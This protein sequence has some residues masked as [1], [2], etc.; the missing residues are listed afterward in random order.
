MPTVAVV[1]AVL[2]ITGAAG[3]ALTVIAKVWVEFGFTPLLAVRVMP[4]AVPAAVGVPDSTLP[5]KVSQAG[6]PLTANVGA[7]LPVVVI[8]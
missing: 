1:G 8:V 3:A 5:D 7:G 4:L 6:L 2:V